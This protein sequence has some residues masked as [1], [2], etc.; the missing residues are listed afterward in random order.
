M[1]AALGSPEPPYSRSWLAQLE[2]PDCWLSCSK[3]V[4]ASNALA[5]KVASPKMDAAMRAEIM[6]FMG[7]SPLSTV[8]DPGETCIPS[9]ASISRYL[10]DLR[11]KSHPKCTQ[12]GHLW[13]SSYFYHVHPSFSRREILFERRQK[14]ANSDIRRRC[15]TAPP[16]DWRQRRDGPHDDPPFMGRRLLLGHGV[17]MVARAS[18][19]SPGVVLRS[20]R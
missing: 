18:L 3:K 20:S 2:P 19:G 9:P 1:T 4:F 5:G 13:R 12:E 15:P 8:I 10:V 14:A 11:W 17:A 7:R 6:V 16:C